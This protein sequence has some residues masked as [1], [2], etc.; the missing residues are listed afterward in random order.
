MKSGYENSA[1]P[2]FRRRTSVQLLALILIALTQ[3]ILP[4]WSQGAP[5]PNYPTNSYTV[6]PTT[7]VSR[8]KPFLSVDGSGNYNVFVPSAQTNSVGTTWSNNTGPGYSIPISQFLIVQPTTTLAAIN[9]ALAYGQNL[10]FTPGIYQ[11]SGSI[12]IT[13]PNTIVL[14]L[15]YATLIPQTGTAAISV[16]DV[17]GVQIAG[18]IIDAGPISSPVLLQIGVPGG[19][20][21]GRAMPPRMASSS[22]AIM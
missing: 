19:A 13:N 2:S 11:Y 5:T 20:R 1:I 15:G 10:I 4:A 8:E 12:N 17:D 6:L 16:A 21:F 9:S 14:G 18:L 22:M 7:P 3:A